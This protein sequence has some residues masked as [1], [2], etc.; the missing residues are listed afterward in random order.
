MTAVAVPFRRALT[1]ALAA[2]A[3]LIAAPAAAGADTYC[4]QPASGS[5]CSQTFSTRADALAQAEEHTGVD[6]IRQKNGAN[7]TDAE[8]ADPVSGPSVFD[9]VTNFMLTWLPLI[10]M[11]VI[12][13]LIGLT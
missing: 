13:L 5:D 11:G 2:M 1:I 7:T 3:L 6:T 4:V 10:F 9:D 8:V 12:C